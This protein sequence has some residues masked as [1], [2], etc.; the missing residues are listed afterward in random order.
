[1]LE[2]VPPVLRNVLHSLSG[3]CSSI[4]GRAVE[5]CGAADGRELWVL[6]EMHQMPKLRAWLLKDGL[7]AGNIFAA[8]TFGL[9]PEGDRGG[10]VEACR[11]VAKRV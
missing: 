1:M 9:L 11:G 4:S 5:E 2:M 3:A 8:C 10:L 6:S 7:D